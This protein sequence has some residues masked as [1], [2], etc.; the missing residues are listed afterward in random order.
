MCFVCHVCPFYLRHNNP[1]QKLLQS[2]TCSLTEHATYLLHR[3]II[4]KNN[5]VR[6]TN[7]TD[8]LWIKVINFANVT[9]YRGIRYR[10]LVPRPTDMKS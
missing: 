7:I 8:Q 9:F 10:S 4:S 5:T 6:W 2:R 1:Q 3:L